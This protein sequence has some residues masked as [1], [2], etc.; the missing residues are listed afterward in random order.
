MKA[1]EVLKILRLHFPKPEWAF[2]EELR[3]GSGWNSR[4]TKWEGRIDAWAMN[5][6]PS[7]GLTTVSFE[8]KVSRGDWLRELNDPNK[9]KLAMTLCNKFYFVAPEGI[10]SKEEVPDGCGL[11]EISKSRM[12]YTKYAPH[13][14]CPN[15]PWR[16][17]ASLARRAQG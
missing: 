3:L 15:P 10:I 2:I 6:Y 7:K 12:R 8:V 4:R 13:R 9:R 5:C 14:E 1:K 16:F 17:V 11:V